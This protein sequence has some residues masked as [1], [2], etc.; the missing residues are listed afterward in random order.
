MAILCKGSNKPSG[1]F[2]SQL[3]GIYFNTPWNLK[4]PVLNNHLFV[5]ITNWFWSTDLTM[6]K[7]SGSS[8][9]SLLLAR[10]ALSFVDIQRQPSDRR[11]ITT[12]S[13]SFKMNF[14]CSSRKI[15]WLPSHLDSPLLAIYTGCSG[16]KLPIRNFNNSSNNHHHHLPFK[17]K[18]QWPVTVSMP[19]HHQES[20][21]S[22]TS[23]TVG[24][25]C[26][27]KKP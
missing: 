8:N 7:S 27:I 2:K 26:C 4:Y 24:P 23:T 9:A 19:H 10:V 15:E 14:S 5:I 20:T 22:S 21:S 17:Y 6:V 18:A 11:W 3:V 25:H 12:T 13:D 16:Q 1:F